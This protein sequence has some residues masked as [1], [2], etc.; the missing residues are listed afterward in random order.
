[1]DFLKV[2]PQCGCEDRRVLLPVAPA[3]SARHGIC[4]QALLALA[5]RV[6]GAMTKGEYSRSRC[7]KVTFTFASTLRLD[8]GFAQ[9]SIT[10]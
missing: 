7:V 8:N 4:L 3:T 10:S 6:S 5:G 2:V 1:M 9:V